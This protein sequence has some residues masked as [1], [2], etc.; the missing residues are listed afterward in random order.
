MPEDGVNLDESV[1]HEMRPQELSEYESFWPNRNSKRHEYPFVASVAEFWHWKLFCS[2][3]SWMWGGGLVC[4]QDLILFFDTSANL[5]GGHNIFPHMPKH[6]ECH[7]INTVLHPS[8]ILHFS[9]RTGFL[10]TQSRVWLLGFLSHGPYIFWENS[11]IWALR[12]CNYVGVQ[13]NPKEHV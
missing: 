11:F 12:N 8:C 1:T 10:P 13:V 5:W 7:F 6:Y 2:L 3:L 4:D 9:H